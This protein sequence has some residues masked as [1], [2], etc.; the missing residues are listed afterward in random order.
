VSK[1]QELLTQ[2]LIAI[3]VVFL[4]KNAMKTSK[5][6]QAA[7]R[8]PAGGVEEGSFEPFFGFFALIF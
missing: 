3:Y 1:N 4:L 2:L 7:A 8:K 6:P 5:T